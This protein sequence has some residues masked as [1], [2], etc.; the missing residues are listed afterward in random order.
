MELLD[1]GAPERTNDSSGGKKK[2]KKGKGIDL[3]KG[4]GKGRLSRFQIFKSE[5]GAEI[6]KTRG[7]ECSSGTLVYLERCALKASLGERAKETENG[8]GLGR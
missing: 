4:S 5:L 7:R 8:E 6:S 2:V 1:R 3:T